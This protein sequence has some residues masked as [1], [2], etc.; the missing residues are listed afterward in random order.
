MTPDTRYIAYVRVSTARQGQSGLGLEA[1]CRAVNEYVSAH[2]GTL[3]TTFTEIESGKGFK[4]LTKRPQLRAALDAC[5]TQSAT[6]LIAKLDRL[7]RNCAFIS[8]LI[9]A[10]CDFIA[11]DMPHANK[12]MLQI[13][14][15]MGEWERDQISARVKAALAAAKA[16]GVRLGATGMD[17][18]RPNIEQRQATARAFVARL[19]AS[20]EDFKRRALTF[21][22]M[23]RELNVSGFRS[24]LGTAWTGSKASRLVRLLDSGY[25]RRTPRRIVQRRRQASASPRAAAAPAPPPAPRS[26][27]SRR[28]SPRSAAPPD[29]R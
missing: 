24:P 23:A 16:R 28:T 6:L 25:D 3:L 2:G 11:A 10:G 5:R 27:G 9:E 7:A 26:D 20:V 21:V 13:F 22:Q 18:L 8:G 14:A 1:Q 17:N 29:Q 12:T 4:P 19:R 15:A